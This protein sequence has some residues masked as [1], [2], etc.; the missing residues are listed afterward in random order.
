MTQVLSVVSHVAETKMKQAQNSYGPTRESEGEKKKERKEKKKKREARSV[1][2]SE[3][4]KY[5]S[6]AMQISGTRHFITVTRFRTRTPYLAQRC[7]YWMIVK[8]MEARYSMRQQR[9]AIKCMY[10]NAVPL[11]QLLMVTFIEQT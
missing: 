4:F 10:C 2:N 11:G 7:L 6:N 1:Q 9:K 3:G 8:H 5:V